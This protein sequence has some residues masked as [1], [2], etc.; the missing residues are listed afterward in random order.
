[1]LSAASSS[2]ECYKQSSFNVP[3]VLLWSITKG[4]VDGNWLDGSVRGLGAAAVLPDDG[5]VELSGVQVDHSEG[6]RG[7]T[8]TKARQRGPGGLHVCGGGVT[9]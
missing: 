8:F 4:G 3:F 7:E 9:G 6:G 1:M 5:G 2:L